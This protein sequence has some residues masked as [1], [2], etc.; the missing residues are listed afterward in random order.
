MK[1]LTKDQFLDTCQS[2]WRMH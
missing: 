2:S 1:G